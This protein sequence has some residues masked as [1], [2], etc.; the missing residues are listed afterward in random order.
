MIIY[1]KLI[2]IYNY[3][4]FKSNK[5]TLKKNDIILEESDLKFLIK[6]YLNQ[7]NKIFIDNLNL[8]ITDKVKPIISFKNVKLSNYGYNKN[9]ITGQLFGKKF[10]LK[11]NSSFEKLILNSKTLVLVQK[12]VL[13]RKKKIIL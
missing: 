6:F 7:K 11:K 8:V 3:Q 5:I 9:L 10:K 1:P 4:N 12:L 2:N 13:M